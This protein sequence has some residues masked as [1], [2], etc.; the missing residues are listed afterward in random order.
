MER[1][2]IEEQSEIIVDRGLGDILPARSD[3]ERL[4]VLTQPGAVPIA[5]LVADGVSSVEV[6]ELTLPDRDEAKTLAVAHSVYEWLAEVGIDRHDTIAG[7]GGGAVTDLAGFVA[8]TYLRGI[9]VV[10]VPTTLLG[11]VDAA[12]GGKTGVNLGGKNLV[13]AFHHPR[14]VVIDLDVLDHLP[15]ELKREGLAEALK[16][17]LIGDVELFAHIESA[18]LQ[19]DLDL[20]VPKA[21]AVKV[22]VVNQDFRESGIRAILNYGHTIGHAVEITARLPHGYAV[23]IGM[24]AAGRI[25]EDLIGFE[26]AARQRDA[27]VG[28]GLPVR[29]EVPNRAAVLGVLAQDKKRDATGLWMVLLRAIATPEIVP[30]SPESVNLGLAEIGITG[31]TLSGEKGATE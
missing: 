2:L 16:A 27:I 17:G 1:F 10:H 4:A 6:H 8:A 13:G 15:L 28:L 25:G 14:R 22:A 24:A 20:V 5:Q 19:A 11:A 18:G 9:E 31:D 23:A 7:V 30:V 21:V 29:V 12:I 26:D 3:R